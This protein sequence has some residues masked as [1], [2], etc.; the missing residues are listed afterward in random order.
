M[1]CKG[2]LRRSRRRRR[3]AATC[4]AQ[5]R[6]LFPP[7][8]RLHVDLLAGSPGARAR[9]SRPSPARAEDRDRTDLAAVTSRQAFLESQTLTVGV[10]DEI[11]R[12]ISPRSKGPCPRGSQVRW[13]ESGISSTVITHRCCS[14]CPWRQKPIWPILLVATGTDRGDPGRIASPAIGLRNRRAIAGHDLGGRPR[15][16]PLA[17]PLDWTRRHVRST[18]LPPGLGQTGWPSWCNRGPC[19]CFGATCCIQLGADVFNG[20]SSSISLANG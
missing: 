17:N 7:G 13:P 16:M 4:K 11:R 6:F 2:A 20:S 5:P 8:A 18:F 10:G 12:R 9:P 1:S 3:T 15:S 14:L 19:P